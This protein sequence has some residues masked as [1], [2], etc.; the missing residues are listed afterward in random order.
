[1]RI[2]DFGLA[3]ALGDDATRA[4]EVAGTPVY[5]APEQLD[6]RPL[7][8]QSDLYALGLVLFELFTGRR[9]HDTGD[10][11]ELRARHQQQASGRLSTSGGVLDPAVSRV[12]E[13][14]LD[15]DPHRRPSSAIQVAAALPG[16]DP[17][18]AALAAGETPSPQMVA[19]AGD[20]GGLSPRAA[21][22]LCA[23]FVASFAAFAV[24]QEGWSKPRLLGLSKSPDVLAARARDTLDQLGFPNRSVDHAGGFHLR[25][26]E[27]AEATLHPGDDLRLALARRHPSPA[28]FWYREDL[29]PLRAPGLFAFGDPASPFPLLRSALPVTAHYPP[30][31]S[32]S[33]YVELAPDG[34][35]ECL[36]ARIAEPNAAT[37]AK[38]S[39]WASVF[40]LA[41][42][43]INAFG[44]AE[45]RPLP[46][47]A[48]DTRLAW[49][50]RAGQPG[51]HVEAASYRGQPV[52]FRVMSLKTPTPVDI[53]PAPVERG[54]RALLWG[55]YPL[56]VVMV[57]SAIAFMRRNLTLGR[58]D[59]AGATRLALLVG[60]ATLLSAAFS[61]A[62][63]SD[64]LV[65][66]VMFGA[67]SAAMFM[68]GSCWVFYLAIEPYARRQWPRT[69][70]GW[71]RFIH[72]EWRDPLAGRELL[73]G[74]V[75]GMALLAIQ[76]PIVGAAFSLG[77]IG[78]SGLELDAY[79]SVLGALSVGVN[80]IG[81]VVLGNL[82]WI[83]LLLLARRITRRDELALGIPIVI[84]AAVYTALATA[85][86][87]PQYLLLFG[88]VV[89]HLAVRTVVYLRVGFLALV[90]QAYTVAVLSVMPL[91]FTSGN[92]FA[93]LAW[94]AVA[95]ASAPALFGLYTSLAGQSVFFN[96]PEDR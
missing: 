17:L 64:G 38:G 43:D 31:E 88:F 9:F 46:S 13:R 7:S 83:V 86:S 72:G 84:F 93:G 81:S 56:L 58:G 78:R 44:P 68:A 80:Q 42:L 55:L 71:T 57:I 77:Q 85:L 25:P 19:A 10:I 3:T 95:V 73:I 35:L 20:R 79:G 63:P 48:A 4:G 37:A 32:G 21:A 11:A 14:C 27:V 87:L 62:W 75:I 2:T 89:V 69:L 49:T 18:A 82:G 50:E 22:L 16:G 54:A 24:I 67:L 41:G 39:D 28:Y 53:A 92:Y 40:K 36:D 12:I 61:A 66:T 65:Q 94:L 33:L 30:R 90:A 60:V 59:R 47:G 26:E 34:R 1:V 29:L 70:T 91:S 15:P 45:P 76:R 5:M 74:A 8:I 6:G 52:L 51:R 23:V 96:A